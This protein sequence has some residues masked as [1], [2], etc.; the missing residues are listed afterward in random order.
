[1]QNGTQP[2]VTI[3]VP[4]YN[5]ESYLGEALDCIL[6]Q[7][8]TDFEVLISDNAST[9]RTQE[10][11][12]EYAA[13]DARITYIRHEVNA[14]AAPNFNLLIDRANG[15]Y[16]KWAACDDLIDR[17]YL[18]HCVAALD[19]NPKAVL[20]CPYATV[21]AADGSFLREASPV[22]APYA[23]ASSLRRFG[24]L[25][26]QRTCYEVF[27]LIRLS[28][29]RKTD[30]IV[31]SYY[32]DG[33]LLAQLAVLG[34][35]EIVPKRLFFARQHEQQSINLLSDRAAYV[36]WFNSRRSGRFQLPMWRMLFEFARIPL[37]FRLQPF[38]RFKALAYVARFA[39]RLRKPLFNDLIS[40]FL[41]VTQRT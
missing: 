17:E 33:V 35:F 16:F 29:L 4:V 20:A 19:A 41:S 28:Q 39:L 31:S 37:R 21:I 7:T 40:L 12:R 18:E 30:G 32:G 1:M 25:L 11:C 10:I 13:R 26:S 22:P 8:F 9:D 23:H 14:G 38:H 27:G 6:A 2:K 5:G 24:S 36:R 3:G 34:P 15:E